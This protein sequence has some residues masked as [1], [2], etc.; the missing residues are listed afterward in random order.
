MWAGKQKVGK[1]GLDAGRESETAGPFAGTVPCL[2]SAAE[3]AP[4]SVA[5]QVEGS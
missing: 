2:P 5:W 1:E 3:H 4:E